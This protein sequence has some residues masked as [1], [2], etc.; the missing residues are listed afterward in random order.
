MVLSKRLC[1]MLFLGCCLMIGLATQ[2]REL[3]VVQEG[4]IIFQTSRSAQ[5][6]AIQQATGS[7]YSHMGIILLRDGKPYVFEASATVRYTPLSSWIARGENKHIVVKRLKN[8]EQALTPSAKLKIRKQ[9]QSF[10]EKPYDA[11]FSWSDERLYCSELVWKI[12]DRALGIQIGH[13][14]KVRE[15]NLG[16][17]A[18]KQKL[19]ERYGT[20]IPWDAP[21]ISPKA[22]FDSPLLVTVIAN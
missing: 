16:S 17:P 15:F 20:Q 22:M 11:L 6:L 1:I 18:V 8:A 13:L 14:Q 5:S 12:Y 7:R 10:A 21:V 3:P 19:R 4:D 2:A 9:A